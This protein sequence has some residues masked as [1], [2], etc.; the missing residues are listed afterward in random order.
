MTVREFPDRPDLLALIPD[1]S[2]ID[3]SKLTDGVVTTDTCNSA[4]KAQRILVEIVSQIDGGVV[5]PSLAKCL[6]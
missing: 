6:D 5:F 1:M 4:R 3:I 2:S